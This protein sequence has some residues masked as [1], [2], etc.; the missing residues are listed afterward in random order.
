ML[1]ESSPF[2][3]TPTFFSLLFPPLSQNHKSK[4]G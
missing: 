2:I 1:L 3:Y 4:S